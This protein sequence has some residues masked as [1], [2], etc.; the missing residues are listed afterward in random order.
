MAA[1]IRHKGKYVT[2]IQLDS[3]PSGDVIVENNDYD[4]DGAL[5]YT[6]EE[7]YYFD[8]A[9]GYLIKSN[10]HADAQTSVGAFTW[11]ETIE[12]GDATFSIPISAYGIKILIISFGIIGAIA[13]IGILSYRKILNDDVTKTIELL[14]NDPNAIFIRKGLLG[15]TKNRLS[16]YPMYSHNKVIKNAPTTWNPL[17]LDYHTLLEGMGS[18]E[19]KR[20]KSGVFIVI[21]PQ[22][23]LGIVDISRNKMFSPK[24]APA[25]KKNIEILYKNY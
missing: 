10:W 6:F 12:L 18:P 20:L 1:E 17:E 16:A 14:R 8:P 9:T 3:K 15:R 4:P 22:D 13:I 7:T 11:D 5:T 24:L 19:K 21:D 23:R 2:A 25:S